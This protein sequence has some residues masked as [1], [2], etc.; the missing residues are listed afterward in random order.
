MPNQHVHI[1]FRN[2]IHSFQRTSQST[3]LRC[4]HFIVLHLNSIQTA[5]CVCLYVHRW[6]E[7]AP[8]DLV[9]SCRTV[10]PLGQLAAAARSARSVGDGRS[11]RCRP[12]TVEVVVAR[13][14]QLAASVS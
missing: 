10:Q 9:S 12:V 13:S 3:L 6:S 11:K 5:F 7:R 14:V 4:P 2:K 8:I 1:H